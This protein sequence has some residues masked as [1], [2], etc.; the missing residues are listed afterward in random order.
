MFF[1]YNFI[2][3]IQN[4]VKKE[5][6]SDSDIEAVITAGA[7]VGDSI[8]ENLQISISEI[9]G[10]RMSEYESS[11]PS[12]TPIEVFSRVLLRSIGKQAINDPDR[13]V[14]VPDIGDYQM[15]VVIRTN[16]YMTSM[17]PGY[18]QVYK[19]I[20]EHYRMD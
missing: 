9:F 17:L 3:F 19:N 14:S 16:I 18:F 6:L 8:Q 7:I 12:E 11:G 20:T 13:A 2:S 4:A 1:C 10:S 5:E 15:P